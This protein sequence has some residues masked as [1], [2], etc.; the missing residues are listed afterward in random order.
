MAALGFRTFSEMIGQ[1]EILDK[2][3]AIDHWKAKGLDFTRI[4]HK[5]D[6]PPEVAIRNSERQDHG[7]DKVLDR[8]LIE[9]AREAIEEKKPVKLDLPIRNLN[10]TA[11]AML[12][13]EIAKRYGH[14]GLPEDTIWVSFKGSAGQSFGAW[15]AHGV[16][17]DLVGEGNDYVGKGLSGGRIIVR[18]P[19]NSAIVPEK[20]IIVGNTVLYGA[21]CRR[22]LFPRHRRRALCRAQLGRHRRGRRHRRPWLRIYDR[23]RGGGDWADGAQFRRRHVRRHR[24]RA[25]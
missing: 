23:R 25:R 14:A 4:F 22:M 8:K 1:T 7:L 16:T 11:G 15:L 21:I 6:V 3:Q 12:S 24:L 19:A 9:L 20:S 10:R 5:P 18:P 2:S 17:L 13:G